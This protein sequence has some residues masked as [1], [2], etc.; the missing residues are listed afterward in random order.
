MDKSKHRHSL[1]PFAQIA[2]QMPR[3]RIASLELVYLVATMEAFIRC[4]GGWHLGRSL[5]QWL[6]PWP[7]CTERWSTT[8]RKSIK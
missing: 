7:P 4:I 1:S 5:G 6:T 3:T 8:L 2:T